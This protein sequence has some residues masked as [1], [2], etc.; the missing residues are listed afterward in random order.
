MTRTIVLVHGAWVTPASWD[1]FRGR[2]RARGYQVIAPPWP[3]EDRP[4]EQLRASPAAELGRVGIPQLTA[5]YA[6]IVRALPEPPILVGHSIGGLVVQL[7]ADR[8]LGSAVVSISPAP[9]R[10]VLPGLTALRANLPVV[11]AWRSWDRALRMPFGRFASTFL[12]TT[13]V[14]ER[15]AVYDRHVV[16]TP[17]ACSW[18][19]WGGEPV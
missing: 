1:S 8:G 18:T 13:P 4:I 10:G 3:H 11:L 12:N 19:P 6:S 9:P 2:Y 14:A 5:H 17:G 7:L 16:P 15:R